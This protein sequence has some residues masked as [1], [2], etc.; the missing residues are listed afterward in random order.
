MYCPPKPAFEKF[1]QIK[2]APKTCILEEN[3]KQKNY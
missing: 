2:Y 1:N 3:K